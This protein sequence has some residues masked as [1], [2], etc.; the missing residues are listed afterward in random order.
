MKSKNIV[1]ELLDDE[2]ET[3]A[4]DKVLSCGPCCVNRKSDQTGILLFPALFRNGPDFST[5]PSFWPGTPEYK[6]EIY[7]DIPLDD[8]K[9]IRNINFRYE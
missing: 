3:I 8:M 5:A 7:L 9:K 6:E 2:S 1:I 4:K